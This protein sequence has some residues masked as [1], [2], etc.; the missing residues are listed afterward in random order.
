MAD[1]LKNQ[2]TDQFTLN[3]EREIAQN[4]SVGASYIY[5]HAANLF[6]NIPINEVTG[7]E[8]EYE[9]IPFTTSAGQQVMLY[10]VVHKDYDGDGVVDG[11][12]RRRGSSDNGT[13]RVQNMP[14]F[15]GVKP[16]RDYHGAPARLQQEVLRP[17]AGA[18]RPSCTRTRMASAAARSGR[19]STSR[20]PMFYDDNWMGNLNY[21]VNNLEGPLPFTPKYELKLSGSYKI[22]RAG[23]R[24]G[25]PA[26]GCTPGGRCGS[27]RTT[28]CTR[29]F[30]DPPGG[31][32]IP[33]VAAGRRRRSQRPRPPA[34]ART[35]STS[36]SR[37]PSSWAEE[38]SR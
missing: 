28:R 32:I 19:T 20:R 3:V 5:K 18:W 17:V 11:A 23:G 36:I 33:G 8:W 13:S 22:P 1:D 7:Q 21:A 9:R 10:S 27:S 14:A 30:G 24:P 6:A 16:K 34:A 31:V 26:T 4:F 38:A 29:E 12:R 2:H 35:S 37:G 15:D 25:R